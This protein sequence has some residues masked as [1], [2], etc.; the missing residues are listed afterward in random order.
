M[1]HQPEE[2]P[3]V[4]AD[5]KNSE[6]NDFSINL[7]QVPVI[8]FEGIAKVYGIEEYFTQNNLRLKKLN[9][10]KINFPGVIGLEMHNAGSIFKIWPRY[11][12]N[13]SDICDCFLPRVLLTINALESPTGSWCANGTHGMYQDITVKLHEG[14]SL[15]LELKTTEF[16]FWIMQ[17]AYEI[18]RSPNFQGGK[19]FWTK[20]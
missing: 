3:Q 9:K 20:A 8:L 18:V 19:S 13:Y 1:T 6:D 16:V 5:K 17:K 7:F 11:H 4:V 14:N 12:K 15:S 2:D 10:E